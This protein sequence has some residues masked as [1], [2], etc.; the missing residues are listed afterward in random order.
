MFNYIT[1]TYQKI[2]CRNRNG[3]IY[4]ASQTFSDDSCGKT[5]RSNKGERRKSQ[6]IKR[7]L[8][9]R[10][11]A[12]KNNGVHRYLRP[13]EISKVQQTQKPFLQRFSNGVAVVLRFPSERFQNFKFWIEILR[14]SREKW[15]TSKNL[16]FP[17]QKSCIL[18]HGSYTTFFFTIYNTY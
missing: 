10:K 4:R 13:W 14:L 7:N 12:S 16:I 2:A 1:M 15:Y 6:T 8:L 17:Y 11:M 18:N 9:F 5:S 3:K